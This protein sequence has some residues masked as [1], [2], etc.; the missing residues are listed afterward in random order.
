MKKYIAII[1][2]FVFVISSNLISDELW[3]KSFVNDSINLSESDNKNI[4]VFCSGISCLA[5]FE[6]LSKQL[7]SINGDN[8]YVVSA[9]IR[10]GNSFESKKLEIHSLK[11]II[12]FDYFYFD[13]WKNKTSDNVFDDAKDGLF[14]KYNVINTPVVL[15]VNGNKSQII[16]YS[17]L[18]KA[19]NIITYI[20]EFFK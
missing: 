12:N 3:V 19:S 8:S 11:K 13:I 14:K 16:D 7:D 4:V 20:R 6:N 1:P 17:R 10:C 5:C 18:S 15:L 2:L 9:L